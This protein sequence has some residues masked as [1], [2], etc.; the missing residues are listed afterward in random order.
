MRLL[1]ARPALRSGDPHYGAPAW[2][3]NALGGLAAAVDPGMF[4][5][6]ETLALT[7]LDLIEDPALLA[8]CQAEFKER[9]GGGIGGDKWVAPPSPR[10]F[11]S[12]HDLPWPQYVTTP[13][14]EEWWMPQPTGGLGVELM[15][16]RVRREKGSS[17]L[18][19]QGRRCRPNELFPTSHFPLPTSSSY[20]SRH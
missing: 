12:P 18:A 13:N 15:S 9:T 2:T 11:Q 20:S 7:A 16:R 8:K 3:Y 4:V 1:T 5:A 19:C 17:A 6:S 14:G 10:D